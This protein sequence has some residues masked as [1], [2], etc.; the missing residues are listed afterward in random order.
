VTVLLSGYSIVPAQSSILPKILESIRSHFS[1][2]NRVHDIFVPHIVLEGSGIMPV[3][4]ELIAS[5]VPEHVR[6]DWE[7][8][9]C[10]FSD[11]GDRFQETRGRGRPAAL[12]DE[13]VARFHI[14]PA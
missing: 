12:G 11:P 9:L 2:S 10:G 6:M 3:V 13:D 8:E 7:W 4:G 5:R 1:I 14:L